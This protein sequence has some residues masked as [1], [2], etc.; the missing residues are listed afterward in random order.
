MPKLHP[1]V[2][3]AMLGVIK[4]ELGAG[5][6]IVFYGANGR[7]LLSVAL[8]ELKQKGSLLKM[9]GRIMVDDLPTGG[10]IKSAA[11]TNGS[12]KRII[13]A[14]AGV[15]NGD[16]RVSRV[17]LEEGGSLAVTSLVISLGA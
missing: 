10:S 15:G 6:R 8:P 16:I 2:R 3:D 17:N 12:G 7:A 5:S 9:P 14:S 11:L 4:D 1:D 13:D